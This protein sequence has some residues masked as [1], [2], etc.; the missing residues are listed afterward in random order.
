MKGEISF[1]TL[2]AFYG[3]ISVKMGGQRVSLKSW[4]LS[5]NGGRNFL[6]NA[7]PFLPIQRPEDGDSWYLHQTM[8]RHN[9]ADSNPHIPSC[10]T[11]IDTEINF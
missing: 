4:C 6:R 8:L 9:Q 2:V 3:T 1:A 5:E 10:C 11:L 7:G